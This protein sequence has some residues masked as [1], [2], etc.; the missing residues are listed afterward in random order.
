M[1]MKGEDCMSYRIEEGPI[2]MEFLNMN[3]FLAF[4]DWRIGLRYRIW[5]AYLGVGI[6]SDMK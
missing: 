3:E 5:V 1:E 4:M 6:W 2:S